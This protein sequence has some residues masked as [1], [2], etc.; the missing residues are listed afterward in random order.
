VKKQKVNKGNDKDMN[1]IGPLVGDYVLVRKVRLK[2][3]VPLTNS[4]CRLSPSVKRFFHPFPFNKSK[5]ALIFFVMWTNGLLLPTFK[6]LYPRIA[7]NLVIAYDT[8]RHII[9]GFAFFNI[10]KKVGTKFVANAGPIIF[11]NFQGIG[12][13]IKMYDFLIR[14]AAREAGISKFR[15]T[16][17]EDNTSS[18][19]FHKKVGFVNM[20]YTEDEYWDGKY[21]KNIQM[22]LEIG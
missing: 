6:R 1:E 21:E 19:S 4:Y 12:L 8:N 22:E 7:A 5:V 14:C 18:I 16:V 13:G 11:K 20:G 2:D 15:V 17:I 9:V 10:T 3:I